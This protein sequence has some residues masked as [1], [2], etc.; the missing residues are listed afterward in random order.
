MKNSNTYCLQP[1][2]EITIKDFTGDKLKTFWPCCMMAN[3]ITENRDTNVLEIKNA[4]E[5]TPQEMYDHPRMVLLRN[6]LLNGIKDSACEVCW[7]QEERGLKSFRQFNNENSSFHSDDG[8][9]SIDITASNICNLRCRMCTPTSS[10]QLMIDHQFF[11]QNQ[12]LDKVKSVTKRWGI[13]NKAYK[14]TESIQ[15]KWML[16]NT[17]KIKLLKASGGEPFYDNK[18][19]KLLEKYIET[20]NAKNTILSFHTNATLFDDNMIN[21]LNQFK[22]N[23]H[24]FS[25]DGVG[26]TYEYIRYPATF[27]Q[28][29]N[30]VIKYLKNV[31][32]Y[33]TPIQ[34]TVIVSAQ[35]LLILDQYIEW[36]RSL[37]AIT[38]PHF[39]EIYDLNRGIAIKHLPKKL[40]LQ[41]KTNLEKYTSNLN[42]HSDFEV[43]SLIKSIDNA[44]AENAE[45]K[46][47]VKEECQLFDLSRNQSYR[48]Y[49]HPDLVNWLDS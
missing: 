32:N 30:S 31:R 36:T 34:F 12:L 41:A 13:L 19:V 49:L 23:D 27:D 20:D 45:N 8:L 18:I 25:V 10:H 37:P 3:Q 26:K 29:E 6:N 9:S 5:L 44:I 15:W 1:F 11:E 17:D 14:T 35:N 42:N 39:S 7:H 33:K 22:M 4:N 2:R 16:E 47:L 28:L 48:S 40:L 38:S 21:I 46:Q 43:E 24:V